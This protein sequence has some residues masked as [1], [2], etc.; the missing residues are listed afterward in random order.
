[1]QPMTHTHDEA[2]GQSAQPNRGSAAASALP[3][4]G[5]SLITGTGM[6]GAS[7]ASSDRPA[8]PTLSPSD[9]Q[10]R[11]CSTYVPHL[12]LSVPFEYQTCSENGPNSPPAQL[13]DG[14]NRNIMEHENLEQA[15]KH[16]KITNT[17]AFQRPHFRLYP[18]DHVGSIFPT[19]SVAK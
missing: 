12:F 5:N 13:R 6:I 9:F 14:T 1:M 4:P 3:L 7:P 2:A 11:P 16:M 19:C 8:R 18:G 17:H 10:C 15:L